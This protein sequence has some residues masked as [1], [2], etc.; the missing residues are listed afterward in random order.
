MKKIISIMTLCVLLAFPA[1]ARADTIV[2]LGSSVP[3][4]DTLKNAVLELLQADPPST[5]ADNYIISYVEQQSSSQYYISV[6]GSTATTLADVA[7]DENVVWTGTVILNYTYSGDVGWHGTYM[8]EVSAELRLSGAGGG[9]DIAFPFAGGSTALYGPN[10]VHG[11]GQYGTNG[12]Y[13]VDF[14]GGSTYGANSMPDTVYASAAGEIDYICKDDN[15]VAIRTKNPQTGDYFLYVH[16]I[17]NSSLVY[18]TNFSRGSVIGKLRHGS[19]SNALCGGTSQQDSSYHVHWMFTPNNGKFQVEGW[20]LDISTQKF[21]YNGKIVSKGGFI[22]ASGTYGG[23]GGDDQPLT[24]IPAQN[25]WDY[26]IQGLVELATGIA[27][28]LPAH[29]S[30]SIYTAIIT[31]I[32]VAS[33]IFFILATT[34]LNMKVALLAAEIIFIL[35]A[36]RLLMTAIRFIKKYVPLL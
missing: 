5:E 20:V 3:C 6:M 30:S 33:R 23:G 25:F 35:E 2:L 27:G 17:D 12:M 24:Q 4:S 21:E 18:G 29:T 14:V 22:T 9:S 8:P 15:N 19:W 28:L 31:G 16:L 1:V 10:G 36:F 13:A 26:L 34:V 32:S 7:L 11:E